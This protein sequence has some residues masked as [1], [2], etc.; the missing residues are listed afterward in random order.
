[1]IHFQHVPAGSVALSRD[2]ATNVL[3]V[4][5]TLTG[6]G[7][8]S[9][10]P[11]HIHQGTCDKQGSPVLYPLGTVAADERGA[12]D[13]MFTVANVTSVPAGQWFVNVHTGPKLDTPEQYRAIACADVVHGGDADTEV[14]QAVPGPGNAV[15][16]TATLAFDRAAGT[17]VVEVKVSGLDPATRHANHIHLGSCAAEGEV[18]YKLDD[19][20]ADANGGADVTTTI[21]PAED[22]GYGLWYVAVHQGPPDQLSTQQGFTPIACADVVKAG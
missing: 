7:P 16:G 14:M 4:H 1:V 6:L 2:A 15:S 13:G 12:F 19:L 21:K 17:L 8:K 9:T 20:V 3:T 11:A 5:L 10:H 22:I 18:K